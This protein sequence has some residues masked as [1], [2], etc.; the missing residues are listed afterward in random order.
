MMGLT[1]ILKRGTAMSTKV[2]DLHCDTV[3][4]LLE[5]IDLGK[6]YPPAHIDLPR[7]IQGHTGVQVFASFIAPTV[8]G[9][10]ASADTHLM[11][12]A[13]EDFCTSNSDVLRKVETARDIT[14]CLETARIG[15]L[16]SIENGHALGSSLKNIGR[17]RER[18][19]R[20]M[21]LVHSEDLE[22]AASV[23]GRGTSCPGLSKFGESVVAAMNEAG[24]IVDISHSHPETVQDVLKVTRKPVV[25]SHSCAKEICSAR[26]NLADDQIKAVADTGGMIGVAFCPH[27]LSEEYGRTFRARCE[28]LN[29]E[30]NRMEVSLIDDRAALNRFYRDLTKRE[31][32]LIPDIVV[33]MDAILDHIDY[34]ADL[35]GDDYVGFGTDFDGFFVTPEGIEGCDVYPELE[36]RMTARGYSTESI[37]KIFHGNFIRVLADHDT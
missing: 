24:M 5:G 13:I 9:E 4:Y 11:I 17:F 19:V 1:G 22:W 16:P 34:I 28:D 31:K 21:T 33:P 32:A 23:S 36:H 10:R 37:R 20:M 8:P 15:V 3:K 14:D 29:S 6:P 12:D 25:A 2:I 30:I 18:G 7:M 26:R 27:F 35:V